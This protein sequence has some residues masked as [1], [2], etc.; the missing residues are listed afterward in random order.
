[1]GGSR[2]FMTH[3]PGRKRTCSRPCSLNWKPRLTPPA[4]KSS[5]T[6]SRLSKT[7]SRPSGKTP[8]TVSSEKTPP[9]PSHERQ[10][11][12][13]QVD[14]SPA[15]IPSLRLRPFL[16]RQARCRPQVVRRPI[17]PVGDGPCPHGGPRHGSIR[18]QPGHAPRRL[19]TLVADAQAIFHAC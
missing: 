4:R 2:R 6:K 3:S 5:T 12:I 1:M 9:V 19:H 10:T 11:P 15:R 17:H 13:R 16:V 18:G 8:N 14:R 7:I